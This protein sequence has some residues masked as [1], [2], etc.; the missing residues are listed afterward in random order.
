MICEN[1]K[2]ITRSQVWEAGS[3]MSES[4]VCERLIA[5]TARTDFTQNEYETAIKDSRGWPL[6]LSIAGI[7]SGAP[8]S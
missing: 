1:W 6:R 3:D 8:V 7:S 2:K 4:S 5:A